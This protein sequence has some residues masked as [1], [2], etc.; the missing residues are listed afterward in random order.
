MIPKQK[1]LVSGLIKNSSSHTGKRGICTGLGNK[2]KEHHSDLSQK[3]QSDIS[4]KLRSSAEKAING[5]TK[6]PREHNTQP[7]KYRGVIM[8]EEA[9]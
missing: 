8:D 2:P 9:Y 6:L 7:G 3:F 1:E 4:K 5:N